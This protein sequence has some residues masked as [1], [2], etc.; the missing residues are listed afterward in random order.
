[1]SATGTFGTSV[2]YVSAFT[3]RGSLQKL[4]RISQSPD[5]RF[6]A[7]ASDTGHVSLFDASTGSLVSAFPAHSAPIRSTTFTSSLFVTASDDKRINVFV[8]LHHAGDVGLT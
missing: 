5:G 3:C 1:M 7:V 8:R 4:I 6:L 2:E